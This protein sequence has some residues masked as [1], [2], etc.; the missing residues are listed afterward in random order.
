MQKTH[1]ID[2]LSALLL[3]NRNNLYD[4]NINQALT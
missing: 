3:K 1:I 4:F 2:T